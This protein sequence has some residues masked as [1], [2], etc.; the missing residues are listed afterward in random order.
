MSTT[1]MD[2]NMV[3]VHR[4]PREAKAVYTS[5]WMRKANYSLIHSVKLPEKTNRKRLVSY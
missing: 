5:D 1:N 4:T 2:R 3:Q